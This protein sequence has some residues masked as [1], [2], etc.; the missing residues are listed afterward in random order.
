VLGKVVATGLM[1][2]ALL[3]IWRMMLSKGKKLFLKA[4]ALEWVLSA[5]L[6]LVGVWIVLNIWGVIPL[7]TNTAVIGVWFFFF[8]WFMKDLFLDHFFAGIK[9]TALRKLKPG[10][11]INL[12]GEECIVEEIKGTET[13]LKT[14]KGTMVVP[15]M[16]IAQ[17][18]I[19]YRHPEELEQK[20]TPS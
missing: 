2:F 5:L 9:L 11:R 3:V 1:A 20:E 17:L 6:V 4:K 8:M 15:N 18:A 13:V 19:I 7:L 14:D 12:F 10:D 16:R